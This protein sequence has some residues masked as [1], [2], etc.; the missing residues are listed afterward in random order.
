MWFALLLRKLALLPWKALK[1]VGRAVRACF[2]ALRA[3]AGRL[4]VQC[5]VTAAALAGA[6]V[7]GFHVVPSA[8]PAW[9][10]GTEPE[11]T[12]EERPLVLSPED[13]P[14]PG[15]PVETDEVAGE[16][17]AP[18]DSSTQAA[19]DDINDWAQSLAHLGI[20]ERAL[21][22][23]GRAELI[24]SVQNPDC[25]LSWTTLAGIGSTETAHGTIG[26]NR[27]LADGTTMTDIVGPEHGEQGPMQFMT[28]TWEQWGADG[29]GDG[30]KDPNNIDDATTA[31]AN[32]LCADGHDLTD[33]TD[34]YDAVYSYNHVDAY[35]QKVYDRA[36]DYGRKSTMA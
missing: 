15:L 16:T 3:P 6:I 36:D 17:A 5:V 21:V 26:G 2:R 35:V 19:V 22:S 23:Y 4:A 12:P 11:P 30:V 14:A 31:A 27:I 20:P 28:E 18:S 33:P 32:Y 1:A 25:H 34:W 29:N 7:A 8:G 10:F 13:A 9:S 24:S